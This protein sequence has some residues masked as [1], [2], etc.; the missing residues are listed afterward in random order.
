MSGF[1]IVPEGFQTLHRVRI[2]DIEIP[3]IPWIRDITP[4]AG[5]FQQFADLMVGISARNTLHIADI[6]V[7]HTDQKI[8]F[9]IILP[10]HLARPVIPAGNSFLLKFLP[11]TIM[12]AVADFFTAGGRGVDKEIGLPAAGGGHVFEDVF[13]HGGTANIAVADEKYFYHVVITSHFLIFLDITGFEAFI[14]NRKLFSRIALFNFTQSSP[15][16]L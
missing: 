5:K 11:G 7:I 13:T 12:Y 3:G 6:P 14:E 9:L 16:K 1:K 10:G 15:Q 2:G 8:E 4:A